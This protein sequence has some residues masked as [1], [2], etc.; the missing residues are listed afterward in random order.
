MTRLLIVWEDDLY[1]S[2]ARVVDRLARASSNSSQSALELIHHTSRSNG[3]FGNYVENTWPRAKLNGTPV[4]PGSIEHL[5]C[6][7]DADKLHEVLPG[8]DA[9]SAGDIEEWHRSASQLWEQHLRSRARA[10]SAPETSVHGVVLRWNK[11]SIVLAG[12][13]TPAVEKHLGFSITNSS[14]E[15]VLSACNPDPRTVREEIFSNTYRKPLTCLRS[16]RE[17]EGLSRL[18]KNAI[19][20][21]DALKD[22]VRDS[23]QIARRMPDLSRIAV[24]ANTLRA[25]SNNIEAAPATASSNSN[26]TPS[27]SKRKKRTRD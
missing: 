4:N 19:Q 14:V 12:Y 23:S 1:K 8:C 15:E 26:A 7:V 17:G 11:E 21:E 22:L 5:I 10:S 27:T 2:S 18:S 24:L 20:I 16:L 6:V 13:D 3:N 9:P 25:A